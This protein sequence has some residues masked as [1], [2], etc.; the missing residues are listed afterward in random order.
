MTKTKKLLKMNTSNT[1]SFQKRY[2]A[3]ITTNS[4]S[5]LDFRTK[6]KQNGTL[7]IC[8]YEIDGRKKNEFSLTIAHNTWTKNVSIKKA[9]ILIKRYGLVE[10]I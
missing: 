8:Q 7:V 5:E 4:I 6:E 9:E 10:S 2:S 3:K 1:L